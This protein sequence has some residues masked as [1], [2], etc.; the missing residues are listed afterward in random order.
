VKGE[1]VEIQRL[2]ERRISCEDIKE[3]GSTPKGKLRGRR[4]AEQEGSKEYRVL[5]YIYLE[6]G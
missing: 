2:G 1:Q 4:V 6:C 3:D 5:T